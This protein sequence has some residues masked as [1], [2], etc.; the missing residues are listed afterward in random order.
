MMLRCR[1]SICHRNQEVHHAQ[2]NRAGRQILEGRRILREGHQQEGNQE[3]HLGD[4]RDLG[5]QADL[6]SL[7]DHPGSRPQIQGQGL[8]RQ[9]LA[10]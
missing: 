3:D 5:S 8:R 10:Q 4:R 1:T 6:Q 7:Q 2:G 9:E